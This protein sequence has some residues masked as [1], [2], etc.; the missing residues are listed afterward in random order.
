MS[1]YIIRLDDA[2]EKRNIANWDRMENLLDSY[3]V[4]PLVGVIPDCQDPMMEQYP[5]DL[6]FWDR[7]HTWETKGWTIAM[8]G[9]R[10]LYTTKCG[11]LNPVNLRSEFAGETVDMQRE[12]IKSGLA[13]MQD[14]GIN[15]KVFFAPS[16]TFDE[17]TIKA[18][19]EESEI[20][21]ISDTIAADVYSEYGI[22][23]VPQQSG[24]V[25]RLPFHTVTFCY[26]PNTMNETIFEELNAFMKI[27]RDKF[28]SFP[29]LKEAPQKSILDLIIEKI[30]FM[31][32]R[33]K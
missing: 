19:K 16:H 2:C 17:N 21:I 33:N 12:K 30:Y 26:H 22:T 6:D 13:I 27:N 32:R 29:V 9:Y 4:K 1:K 3:G 18:L 25:R 23:F 24:R 20:R 5:T 7:V 15:P 14:H 11:G 10:H 28:I 8:H 31:R